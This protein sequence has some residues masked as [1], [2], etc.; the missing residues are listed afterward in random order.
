MRPTTENWQ[1]SVLQQQSFFWS[2]LFTVS[3]LL[4]KKLRWGG[5]AWFLKPLPY[6]KPK[7]LIFPT[8]SKPKTPAFWEIQNSMFLT[9]ISPN[10]Y[11][12][13][14]LQIYLQ[15]EAWETE[16]STFRVPRFRG[17][18]ELVPYFRPKWLNSRPGF[19]FKEV[20]S[21]HCSPKG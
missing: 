18:H 17:D 19:D 13:E 3:R 7:Y 1:M 12:W 21:F 11:F 4:M 16:E 2:P 20:S 14:G 6:F 8:P 15:K 9:F 10:Y 5:S